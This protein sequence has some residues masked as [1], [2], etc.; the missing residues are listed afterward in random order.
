MILP[1]KASDW[2]PGK[3][4][5]PAIMQPKIDGVRGGY[6]NPGSFCGRTLKVF[7]NIALT[8]YWSD[9]IFQGFDGEL[10]HPDYAWTDQPL[11]R[12][13]S[14][15]VGRR[16]DTKVPNL[17]A[18]DYV[19][20]HTIHL[21]Y[22]QR[23]D[24][25]RRLVD[26]LHNETRL[27]VMPAVVVRSMAQL[28]A[29]RER[30]AADG[31]EG[32]IIRNPEAPYKPGYSGRAM[33]CWRIKEF[34]D[35][36]FHIDELIEAQQNNNEAKL[37]PDGRTE[38]SSHKANKVGKGMIGMLRGRILKDVKWNG[39]VL[40]QK[41]Q[42]VDVG[43]GQLTHPEREEGWRNPRLFVGKIGKGKLFPHGTKDKPRMPV[44][45]SIRNKEDL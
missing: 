36:E 12:E 42:P 4:L 44:F 9:P 38:R 24:M 8:N 34:I 21:P 26:K 27:Y 5:F 25:L 45:L 13:T 15:L 23:Y 39:K 22:K 14:G 28:E 10:V 41:G 16:F 2:Q 30:W 1:Q 33:E 11:C 31:Y 35:F 6:W 29:Y 40:F 7:K 37:R 3:V 32:S 20:E 43:P 17:V 18:F 19:D